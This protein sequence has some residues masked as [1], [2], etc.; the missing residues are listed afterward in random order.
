MKRIASFA[1]FAALALLAV[2]SVGCA[3]RTAPHSVTAVVEGVKEGETV[4]VGAELSLHVAT[5]SHCGGGLLSVSDYD[6]QAGCEPEALQLLELW[7]DDGVCVASSAPGDGALAKTWSFRV[8]RPGATRL[9]VRVRSTVHDI[10][11]ETSIRI[12]AG[13]GVAS[14]SRRAAPRAT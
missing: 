10:E 13:G 12:D 1:S 11:L 6:G 9:H 5:D 7:C 3:S 4:P 14:A 2:G 8:L